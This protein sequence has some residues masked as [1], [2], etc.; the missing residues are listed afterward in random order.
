MAITIL[1][2]SGGSQFRD[3]QTND[4]RSL[5]V[6]DTL[7]TNEYIEITTD[8]GYVT[9]CD[10]SGKYYFIYKANCSLRKMDLTDNNCSVNCK[11]SPYVDGGYMFKPLESSPTTNISGSTSWST[12]NYISITVGGIDLTGTVS[13]SDLF[14]LQTA[15][16]SYSDVRS[17]LVALHSSTNTVYL[18]SYN[19]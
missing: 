14:Y 19:Q 4:T 5:S 7:G 8:G 10:S 6:N 2:K 3:I 18:H 13:P 12:G 9:A 11:K 17:M 16:Q 15:L 1:S